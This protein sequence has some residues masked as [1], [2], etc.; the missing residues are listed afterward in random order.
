MATAVTVID[1]NNSEIDGLLFG[2]RW[3]GNITYSFPD[4]SGDYRTPYYGDGEPTKSGF[5]Q[6]PSQIQAAINYGSG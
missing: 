3:S 4:A 1:T 2:V 5:A 6:A